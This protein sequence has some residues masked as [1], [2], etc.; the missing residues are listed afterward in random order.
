MKTYLS[1]IIT[2]LIFAS[3][4]TAED[5][6]R[7][8]LPDGRAFRTDT[9]GNVI[10]DYIAELELSVESLNRRVH[11][12]EYEVEQKQNI[13]DQFKR[14]GKR[15]PKVAERDLIGSGTKSD[16]SRADTTQIN[17]VTTTIASGCSSYEEKI[18][19]IQREL[20]IAKIALEGEQGKSK[21]NETY[22]RGSV[23]D[24]Q[25]RISSLEQRLSAA[26]NQITN[27]SLKLTETEAALNKTRMTLEQTEGNYKQLKANY[28]ELKATPGKTQIITTSGSTRASLSQD[29]RNAIDSQR[30]NIRTELNR[31]RGEIQKRDSLFKKY[32][33]AGHSV[34][35]QPSRLIT[36]SKRTPKIIA[37]R[38]SSATR[39]QQLNSL[40]R[41]I[42]QLENIV[43]E[44]IALVQRMQKLG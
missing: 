40:R 6:T 16:W 34:S 7:G 8:R 20:D 21:E 29:E 25:R 39:V 35:L 15:I 27:T 12:L 36:T 4:V 17:P 32:R 38:I 10:A 43:K 13:I 3:A 30:G 31:L 41:D 18:L 14:R 33:S 42:K 5:P 28:D 23:E 19:N 24:L 22:Y 26:Q 2:C 44:D 37:Q 1:L 9:S 11:G